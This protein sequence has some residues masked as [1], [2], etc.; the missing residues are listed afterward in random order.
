[1]GGGAK[2]KHESFTVVP[3]LPAAS[4]GAD[5]AGVSAGAGAVAA[6]TSTPPPGTTPAA[7]IAEKLAAVTGLPPAGGDPTGEYAALVGAHTAAVGAITFADPPLSAAELIAAHDQLA[8]TCGSHLAAAPDPWLQAAAADQGFQHPTLVG[9]T[10]GK[11]NAL[12]HWLNPAYGAT[13]TTKAKVQKAALK[14]YQAIA[15]GTNTDGVTVADIN[16]AEAALTTLSPAPAPGGPDGGQVLPF[17]GVRHAPDSFIGKQ[18]SVQ[19]AL[20]HYAASAS[21]LPARRPAAEVAALQLTPVAAMAV[22]GAHRKQFFA[23]TGGQTWMHKPHIGGASAEAEACASEVFAHGGIPSVPVYVRT[24][25]K[26]TGSIQPMLD[27]VKPLGDD[28]SSLSQADV[29]AVVRSHVGAWLVGD[30]DAKPDNV[31]RTKAG[32]LVPV[33]HG[34]AFKFYGRDSLDLD[35]NPNHVANGD[36]TLYQKV[37]R[38]AAKG[39]LSPGVRLRPEAAFGVI[40]RYE[41]LPDDTFRA[42]VAPVAREGVKHRVA[43]YSP[44]AKLAEKRLGHKPSEAEVEAELVQHAVERKHSLRA[45]FTALFASLGAAKEKAVA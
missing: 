3:T 27:H 40:K 43:W 29:D 41:A 5:A 6:G 33:D 21:A 30:H 23:D 26:Q 16:A 1:M 25:G 11:P 15:A 7:D 28:M 17:P 31:L 19:E 20:Q 38:A 45:C 13:S 44:M 32:G 37:Y 8:A 36:R 24:V 9:K 18:Q 22:G 4:G 34:Q 12:A 14:R 42:A 2:K 35:Y 10:P 39:Q